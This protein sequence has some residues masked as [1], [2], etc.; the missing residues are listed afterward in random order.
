[1]LLDLICT[2]MI[3]ETTQALALSLSLRH[4]RKVTVT[5]LPGHRLF[6]R[7]DSG[8]LCLGQGTSGALDL[9]QGHWHDWKRTRAAGGGVALVHDNCIRARAARLIDTG[10]CI[11]VIQHF[12]IVD[13]VV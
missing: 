10:S 11:I 9:A 12:R 13:C 7:R 2:K 3:P 4:D 1:M 5:T 8:A 6:W